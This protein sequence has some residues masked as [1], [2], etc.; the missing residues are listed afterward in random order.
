MEHAYWSQPWGPV[1]PRRDTRRRTGLKSWVGA[2][3]RVC[4]SSVSAATRIAVEFM[5]GP[6]L[7]LDRPCQG[8]RMLAAQVWM[9]LPERPGYSPPASY[10]RLSYQAGANLK[11]APV[12]GRPGWALA[13][14][15]GGDDRRGSHNEC[16]SRRADRRLAKHEDA[17]PGWE[18]LG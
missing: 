9:G 11:V 1:R 16:A 4:S 10:M 17:T 7:R 12:V 2:S 6:A 18:Q 14:S 13:T 3:V 8:P 5:A 15:S